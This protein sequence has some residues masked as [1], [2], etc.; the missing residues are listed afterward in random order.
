MTAVSWP[1]LIAMID[2]EPISLHLSKN[3]SFRLLNDSEETYFYVDPHTEWPY[4]ASDGRAL[5]MQKKSRHLCCILLGLEANFRLLQANS[6]KENNEKQKI[7]TEVFQVKNA[8][9]KKP[10]V[11]IYRVVKKGLPSL[12]SFPELKPRHNESRL[13]SINRC[14]ALLKYFK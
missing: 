7:Y 10:P 5:R 8:K 3:A 9:Q 6:A 12:T 4:L 14:W 2:Y 11:I 1:V 13:K